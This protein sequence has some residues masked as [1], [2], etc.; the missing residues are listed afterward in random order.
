MD[1]LLVIKRITVYGLDGMPCLRIGVGRTI[2][3]KFDGLLGGY[4]CVTD[5]GVEFMAFHTE[6][7]KC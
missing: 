3:G 7:I 2:K 4:R 6:V 5:K 1:N